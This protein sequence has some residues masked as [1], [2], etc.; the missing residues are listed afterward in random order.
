ML[1]DVRVNR[2]SVIT[3]PDRIWIAD[4]N[5]SADA[6]SSYIRSDGWKPGNR[7]KQYRGGHDETHGGVRINIDTNWLDLGQ[8]SRPTYKRVWCGGV[9]VSYYRYVT[10]K[11]GMSGDQVEALQ[12]LMTRQGFYSGTL[13]GSMD[14]ATVAA[15]RKVRQARGIP[16]G[17]AAG[18]RVWTSLLA[19]GASGIKKY[20]AAGEGVRQ[21]Q[22]AMNAL[23]PSSVSVTGRSTRCSSARPSSSRLGPASRSWPRTTAASSWPARVQ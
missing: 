10:Q 9:K 18:P 11:P 14:S 6:E 4:W 5:G 13:T 22:R 7:M 12:C 8:G 19:W 23:H 2:P 17:T 15:V 16:A 3:L 21:L 20:G 1:D